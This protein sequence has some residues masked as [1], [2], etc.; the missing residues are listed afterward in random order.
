MRTL[1]LILLALV[2]ALA[3]GAASLLPAGSAAPTQP[4]FLAS[5]LG[6]EV[7]GTPERR[8]DAGEHVS[9]P[10]SGYELEAGVHALTLSSADPDGDSWHHFTKGAARSTSFGAEAVVVKGN[11]VEQFLTVEKR[12]GAK[13]WR[14]KLDTGTL[15]PHLRP[16]GSVL[17][18][19][20][21]IVAGFRILPAA[22]LD[23]RGRDISPAGTQ[24]G[25]E[26]REGSWFL[27]LDLDDTKLTL[28]Y[29]IDPAT[30]T[31]R[32]S[33]SANNG[34]GATTLTITKP[35]GLAVDDQMIAQVTARGGTGTFICAPAGWTSV[36]RRDSTTTLAQEIF[37]KTAVAADVAATNF[38]F[39]LDDTAGCGSPTS[40]KASG[41]IIAYYG[42]DNSSPISAS[43]GQANA[44]SA[45]IAAP[46]ITPGANDVILGVFGTATG[47]TVTAPTGAPT[48]TE[49]WDTAS[50]GAMAG[51]RTTSELA[52]A[53]STGAA[54]GTKTAVAAAA[55]VNIGQLVS[56]RLDATNPSAPTLTVT[57]SDA[58]THV[59]GTTLY[60]LPSGN[61][62]TFDVAAT[63]TD[64]QS[65][66]KH[67]SFPGLAGSFTPITATNDTSSPYS[68]TYTWTTGA[69]DSGAKTVTSEDNATNQ[70]TS[71]FTLTADSAVPVSGALT[72]NGVA[73][74]GGGSQ[75]YDGDG[76]FTIGTRTDYTDAGSGLAS[77]TLTRE[78]GTLTADACSAYGAPATLVGAPGPERPR[79]GLLPLRP[80]RH[81]QRRQHRLDHDHRQGRH[82]RPRRSRPDARR[83][84]RRRSHHRHHRLLPPR[85]QRLLRRHRLRRPTDSPASSTTASRR[86]PASPA[87]APA[88]PAPTRSPHRRS[89]TAPSRSPPATRRCSARVPRTSRSP[90][91]RPAP[92]GGA[93]TVN[94]VAASGGGSQSYDGD[95]A[96]TIGTR[97]DYTPTRPPA[98]RP[99][100]SLVSRARSTP[101]PARPT[102]R[103]PRSSASPAQSG[104]A[105][106]CYRYVLTGTD[107][108]GNA[109]TITTI[110]KVDTSDPSA[111]SLE[112]RRH[113]RR[114]PHH[115][116]HR[117]LPPRRRRLV[118]RHRLVDRRRSPASPRTPSRP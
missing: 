50:T 101:T 99:R 107:N 78:D 94:G 61:G 23:G 95:G 13:R 1:R 57:E 116:H 62:G 65:G 63:A 117:L 48:F 84:E 9:L 74:S 91:T 46:T 59:S 55:A 24:W 67:I 5:A 37:R 34:G 19:P 93:L 22:I 31:L 108:V 77:S 89:P 53:L 72:V 25:L 118:R 47:T 85:R 20:G 12:M 112:P 36:D 97:T 39:T 2:A 83:L 7:A 79:D 70:N 60:Y 98:S 56:L 17:V 6:A 75:S 8:T 52:S 81:R 16:D 40:L 33:A 86:S 14:W 38:A 45:N 115:R 80:H 35:A 10:R 3:G 88:P 90:P 21:N 73:A 68:Q 96:F 4:T 109:T 43:T 92:T 42:V 82:E 58:D 30:I 102:A 66:L 29:V 103:R 104:L 49:R 110:V 69:T 26:R 71:A 100:R 105:T 64:G 18:S 76:A 113:E 27:A 51:T 111:P 32:Q 11:V 106:G 54:T 15:K 41:G 44:S 28:P 87:P 114:R